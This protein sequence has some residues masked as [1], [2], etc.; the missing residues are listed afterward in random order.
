MGLAPIGYTAKLARS[1]SD[2]SRMFVLWAL[3]EHLGATIGELEREFGVRVRVQHIVSELLREQLVRRAGK[4]I[5]LTDAGDALVS[6]F[7]D[8]PKDARPPSPHPSAGTISASAGRPS[9]RRHREHAASF[10]DEPLLPVPS[11]FVGRQADLEWLIDRLCSQT[12][13]AAAY[14]W[15]MAGIGKT[16]LAGVA[17][18]VVR[19]RGCFPDGI[20]VVECAG[21]AEAQAL[22]Q[23]V[24]ATLHPRGFQAQTDDWA[25]LTA[26][27]H[28]LVREKQQLIVLDD[29]E[30]EIPVA[31][32]ARPLVEAG[33]TVLVISRHLAAPPDTEDAAIR[34]LAPLSALDALMVLTDAY[35]LSSVDSLAPDERAAAVTL[36]A[37]LQYHP[38]A[39][40]LAGAYAA[41]ARL[42]LR[43]IA[44][45]LTDEHADAR[46]ALSWRDDG[47]PRSLAQVFKS[48]IDQ[49]PKGTRRLFIALGA[50]ATEE[51]SAGCARALAVA[52]GL[53]VP[54]E[55]VHLLASRALIAHT[56]ADDLPAPGDRDRVRTNPVLQ[57]VA[58]TL[59]LEWTAEEQAAAYR[60]V[61]EYFGAYVAR[62]GLQEKAL[63]ADRRNIAGALEWAHK[64]GDDT[65]MLTLCE[66]MRAFWY[67]RWYMTECMR[68]LQWGIVAGDALLRRDP[69]LSVRVLRTEVELTYAQ[70]LRRLGNLDEAE[71]ILHR[72]LAA[73][74]EIGDQKG[75]AAVLSQL[76]M[77]S[78][79]RGQ[80]AEAKR[81]L[82][83]SLAL[84]RRLGDRQGEGFDLSQLGRIALLCGKLEEARKLLRASRVLARQQ[85][86]RRTE[87]DDL[88]F[89][90]AVAR[91]R[92]RLESA[93]R[94]LHKG[95]K[96]MEEVQDLRGQSAALHQL[97]VVLKIRGELLAAE[98]Y[99][100]RSLHIRGEVKDRRGEG[101]D[102]GYLGRIA[103]QRGRLD[104]AERYFTQSLD[105]AREVKDR[106]GEGI[107]LSQMGRVAWER[108][109][110]DEA[111]DYFRQS[112]AIRREVR[113]RRGEAFDLG[114]LGRIAAKR[115]NWSSAQELL[116]QS[117]ALA[118]K[119]QDRQGE[120]YVLA[121]L[122]DIAKSQRDIPTAA[123][124]LRRSLAIAQEVGSQ[125]G[126]AY[127]QLELGRLEV[128]HGNDDDTVRELLVSAVNTFTALGLPQE[129]SARQ[130]LRGL[131]G[132]R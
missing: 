73:R 119:V 81:C 10:P 109:R 92:G 91:L 83:R 48:S 67:N 15:G 107:V 60:G 62:P 2:P 9:P 84:R 5:V 8:G 127:S 34:L 45:R 110:L 43:E 13:P 33:T 74:Q 117:L 114:Y 61:A 26:L 104:E 19:R 57:A 89:L 53:D 100:L 75:V 111:E 51:F 70:T 47:T 76:G 27:A 86:D 115:E 20:R 29:V 113:D 93:E 6:L 126:V 59:L 87:G 49:L 98:E 64:A 120:G 14:L 31:A 116:G 22:F 37:F 4:Q 3:K 25:Q 129:E 50:I 72:N 54:D 44:D 7:I 94:H 80:M 130:T 121:A 118:K 35:G 65:L 38:L 122:A 95:L 78:R 41:G 128:E 71:R 58:R 63:L 42:Q 90:G 24:L 108:G 56:E 40:R 97:G 1:L 131:L 125:P 55:H 105:I 12:P 17:A 32:I 79:I 66:G 112:L 11:T 39:V 101:E 46:Q 77:I 85:H 69:S 68:Y 102:L 96:I 88:I 103:R 16:S 132:E 36:V 21:V 52:I 28:E 124:Y 99:I 30:P 123:Q 106:R 23:A 18:R 82:R